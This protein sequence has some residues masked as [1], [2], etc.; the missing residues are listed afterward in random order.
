MAFNNQAEATRANMRRRLKRAYE[1]LEAALDISFMTM[2]LTE[3]QRYELSELTK[4][5]KEFMDNY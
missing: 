2:L 5:V 3:D 1:A 4:R